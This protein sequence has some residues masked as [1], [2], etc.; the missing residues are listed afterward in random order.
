MP[1]K[2]VYPIG[3]IQRT[4]GEHA[5]IALPLSPTP[6]WL[7]DNV[8]AVMWSRHPSNLATAKLRGFTSRKSVMTP[9]SSPS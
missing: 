6:D 3:I 7:N 4:A 9:P 8:P 5:T 2:V 1:R